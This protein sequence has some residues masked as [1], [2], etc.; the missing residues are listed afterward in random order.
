MDD[1]DNVLAAAVLDRTARAFFGVDGKAR[2]FQHRDVARHARER[3]RQRLSQIREA[4]VAVSQR[5]QQPAARGI[6][7]RG[8][9]TIQHRIFNHSVDYSGRSCCSG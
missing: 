8:V 7:E 4:G 3:H 2:R 1:D 9:R 6:R 5:F